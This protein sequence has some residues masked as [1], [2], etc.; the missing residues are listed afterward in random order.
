MKNK[1]MLRWLSNLSQS[2]L[3]HKTISYK[4]RKTLKKCFKVLVTYYINKKESGIQNTLANEHNM[5]RI[6]G[7]A[8][9]KLKYYT[10]N[11]EEIAEQK[12]YLI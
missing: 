6:A 9:Q 3:K 5:F 12:Q 7:I 8:L 4:Q 10:F 2:K 11:K 1:F